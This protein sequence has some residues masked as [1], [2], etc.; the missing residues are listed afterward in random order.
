MGNFVDFGGR[1][2]GGKDLTIKLGR[3]LGYVFGFV[4]LD[5]MGGARCVC[6]RFR[7]YRM[8]TSNVVIECADKNVMWRIIEF[9]IYV[10]GLREISLTKCCVDPW[11]FKIGIVEGF[12]P[13]VW[14]LVECW[15]KIG[16]MLKK[17]A[18]VGGIER[19][20]VAKMRD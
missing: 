15:G 7:D 2:R 18:K 1:G 3:V 16:G 9:G 17:L 11:L 5:G 14:Q 12:R 6:K 13:S 8:I 20:C 4:G 10:K 19:A